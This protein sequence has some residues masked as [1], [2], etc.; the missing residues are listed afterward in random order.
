[1]RHPRGQAALILILIMMVSSTVAL[2]VIQR[3]I[4]EIELTSTEQEAAE[5]L[6][7]AEA[8]VEQGLRTLTAGEPVN[9]EGAN[10]SVEVGTEGSDG[11]LTD[12]DLITGNTLEVNLASSVS[13][14][15]SVDIY[16]GDTGDGD[17]SPTAALEV[18]RYQ[19]YAADDYRVVHTAYDP[20][21]SRQTSNNFTSPT[22]NP[23]SA[24]GVTFR[25]KVNIPIA[26]E[27]KV[28]RVRTVYNRAKLA[29]IP[30][31][32]GTQLPDLQHRI[33]S[34]GQTE[35]GIVRKIEVLRDQPS[36]P[37][38]FDFALYSGGSLQQTQ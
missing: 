19:Q 13:P 16:W 9:L 37:Q 33:V 4:Q 36:L 34:T 38:F 30:L 5:A 26:A 18:L 23:G 2:T 24:L 7:A 10:Y 8:G 25:A 28:L 22:L 6:Q 35:S 3:T 21:A 31:P 11:Y 20:V 29:I 15:T 17:E 32:A 1:M 27:D 14:P 12:A